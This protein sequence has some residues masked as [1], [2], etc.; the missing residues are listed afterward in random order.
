V[1]AQAPTQRRM[2][3]IVGLNV[4]LGDGTSAGR[5]ADVVYGS[6]GM[7]DYVTLD[8]NGVFSAVPW[9]AL[10]WDAT[11][12]LAIL[13]LTRT[14]FGT[15]PTFGANDWSNI[16]ANPNFSQQLQNTFTNFQGPNGQPLFN[17]LNNNAPNRMGN[18][19]GGQPGMQPG[20]QPKALPKTPPRAG[21][22]AEAGVRTSASECSS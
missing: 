14:Q 19:V 17:Q 11:R 7:I 1:I 10:N 22:A 20:T 16:L 9:A 3:S 4:T 8:N 15:V 5:V 13:P 12:G 2:S 21:V 18:R 6:N